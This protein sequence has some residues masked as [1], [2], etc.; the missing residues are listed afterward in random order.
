MAPAVKEE[1]ALFFP[2]FSSR[3][4]LIDVKSSE[5]PVVYGIISSDNDFNCAYG[6]NFSG[7]L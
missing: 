3:A 4:Q 6:I 1:D 2:S 5:P 7:T